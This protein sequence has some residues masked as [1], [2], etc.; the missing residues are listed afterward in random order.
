MLQAAMT[1]YKGNTLLLTGILNAPPADQ[2]ITTPVVGT[3][4]A[5]SVAMIPVATFL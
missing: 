4:R 1:V 2:I 3:A 5:A